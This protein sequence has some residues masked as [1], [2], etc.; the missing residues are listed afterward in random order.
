MVRLRRQVRFCINPP[1][2]LR[3]QNPRNGY[4]GKPPMQGL[5]RF[6]E[7]DICAS[8]D[9]DPRTGYLLNIKD[10]DVAATASAIP[11]I[12]RACTEHPEASAESLLGSIC[13]ALD[14]AL[15]GRLESVR[16]LLTP[17]YSIEMTRADTSRVTL[18]QRFDF[19]AAH[20]LHVPSMS[21]E[22]NRRV[23]GH[24][25]NPAGHGHNYR[26]EPAVQVDLDA[27]DRAFSLVDLERVT[28]EVIL[29][30]FDHTHLNEDTTHFAA[31]GG[32]TPSVENIARVFYELL[33]PAIDEASGGKATLASMTVWE[34]D[35]TS[36]TYPG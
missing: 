11:I 17:Y 29:K 18:R 21:A 35:R 28:D 14:D 4:G 1:G 25:N 12:E 16:W 7:L 13:E 20:R 9:P 10:I 3:E 6:Y 27:S 26:I 15:G 8:G 33:A 22:E 23:F 31:E 2:T 19:A 36:C 30:R 32:V 34:T 24:C 5:G